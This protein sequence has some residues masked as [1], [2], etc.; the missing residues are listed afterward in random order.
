MWL[1]LL[2]LMFNWSKD[3]VSEPFDK[4]KAF[5]L[6]AINPE[7]QYVTACCGL[8]SGK[9]LVEADALYAC[10]YGPNPVMLQ[11]GPRGR[12]PMEVW[13]ASK[14]YALAQ[15]MFETFRWRTPAKIW[16]SD[17]DLRKWGLTRDDRFTHYLMPRDNCE[18]G[19]PIKLRV[20]T[21]SDPDSMRST[22]TL[23]VAVCDELA[24]WKPLSWSNLQG[25]GIVARTKFISGT[26]TNGKNFVYRQLALPAGYGG[27][28][29]TDD[30]LRIHTWTSADNPYADK[31]HIERLRK[32]FGKEYAKQELEG[33]FTD[34]IGYVYGEFDRLTMMVDPP[35]QD[36]GDY[37][38][39]T[40][41]IDFGWTDPY[42]ACVWGMHKDDDGVDRWYQLEEIHETRCT[43]E[44]VAP[45]LLKAQER[46]KVRAWYCDKRLPSSVQRLQRLGVMAQNVIDIHAE[47]DRRTIKVMLAVCQGLMQNDQIRIGKDHDWTAEEYENYHYPDPSEEN[48]KNTNDN[49]V[50]WMNH[51]MDAKRYALCSVVEIVD[52]V[53]VWKRDD[54]NPNKMVPAARTI[55]HKRKPFIPPTVDQTLAAQDQKWEEMEQARNG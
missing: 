1:L 51:H 54:R 46:W 53:T 7:V 18:D 17:K 35:S 14:S 13:I 25:R 11:E 22:P 41:G 19:A 21:A 37:E 44:D 12:T 6:D 3:F 50:D 48:P 33:L 45:L 15:S 28:K 31:A 36:P 40:A 52:G 29:V 2:A 43:D 32:I 5:I 55:P 27:N 16:A 10:L 47:D 9:S 26:T 30:K 39:I 20:R 38:I 42:A 34:A 49:P 8:Q 24:R 23:G 4:Q